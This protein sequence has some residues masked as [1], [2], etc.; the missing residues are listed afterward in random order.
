MS[1]NYEKNKKRKY[2]ACIR[3]ISILLI[4]IILVFVLVFM[5]LTSPEIELSNISI[6]NISSNTMAAKSPNLSMRILTK[7][8]IQNPNFGRFKY[9]DTKLDVLY[10]GMVIGD[11][12][13]PK[14]R[15][16]AKKTKHIDLVVE[17]NADRLSGRYSGLSKDIN[18]GVVKLSG[19]VKLSGKVYL[20][21]IFKRKKS[22]EMNCSWEVNL[23]RKSIQNLSC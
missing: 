9:E 13:I 19:H 17:I 16:T 15:V 22:G 4:A 18:S 5:R 3:C 10:H 20:I 1:K 11:V 8:S 7:V 2:L 12:I 14:G 21:M 23:S 6:D